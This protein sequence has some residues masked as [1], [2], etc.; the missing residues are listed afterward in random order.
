[1]KKGDVVKC[2]D[3]KGSSYLTNGKNYN[4]SA[5]DGDEGVF[6]YIGS[7][8]GFEIID[9]AIFQYKLDGLHGLFEVQ[10]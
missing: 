4:V 2:V 1:M 9:D 3:A 7:N 8:T 5:G 10:Q 6:G